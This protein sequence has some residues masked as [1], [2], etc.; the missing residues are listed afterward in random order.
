VSK[1][2]LALAELRTRLQGIAIAD[3]YET[4]AGQLVFLAETPVLGPEDPTSAVAIVVGADEPGF[5][6]EHIVVRLP[7]QVQALAK[8]DADDPWITVEAIIG[9]I[10]KAVET[11]RDLGGVLLKRGLERGQTVPME[12]AEGSTYVGAGVEYRLVL[13]ELWGAP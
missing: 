8:A 7:V 3:G 4:D 13:A 11:D 9:D 10:K 2:A 5:Q 12:R 1:R 6:G